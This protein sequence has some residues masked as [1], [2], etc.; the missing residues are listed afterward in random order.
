MEFSIFFN[1]RSFVFL[2]Y[3][4]L[5]YL[6]ILINKL[7]KNELSRPRR[8]FLKTVTLSS[9]GL[10]AL[11]AIDFKFEQDIGKNLT[12]MFQGDSITDAGRNRARYYANDSAGLGNGYVTYIAGHLLG[13]NPGRNI[14]C[15]NRGISGN[16]VYQLSDRWNDDCLNLRPDPVAYVF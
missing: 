2:H 7:M 4:T 8:D 14:K 12:I 16:K 3:L 11:P 15:Y 9:F 6:Y 10:A 1:H 13:N 5:I